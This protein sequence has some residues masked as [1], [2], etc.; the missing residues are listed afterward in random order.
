MKIRGEI[1][2][3]GG[4]SYTTEAN[5]FSLG[6]S[7]V[8]PFYPYQRA[9]CR[10]GQNYIHVVWLYNS[11]AVKYAR[12]T[13]NGNSWQITTWGNETASALNY[14]HI[15]CDGNNITVVYSNFS[16]VMKISENNGE[17]WETKLPRTSGVDIPLV[18]RRGQR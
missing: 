18:E 4:I 10:D 2:G 17:T 6:F 9:I 5:F 11:T 8:A 1:T 3:G 16:L 12:S 13:D 14:P 7:E 15:S